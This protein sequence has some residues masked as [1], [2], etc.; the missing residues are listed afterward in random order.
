MK[1]D[2]NERMRL[3]AELASVGIQFPVSIGIGFL[4]GK[5]LDMLFK[6]EPVLTWIFSVFG[7]VAAFVNVFRLNA[8]LSRVEA[9]QSNGKDEPEGQEVGNGK[10]D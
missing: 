3:V 5:G 4:I 1:K 8:E 2:S 10:E 9:E 6:T 7:V